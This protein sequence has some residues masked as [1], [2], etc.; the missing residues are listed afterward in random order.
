MLSGN[1]ALWLQFV[2]DGTIGGTLTSVP[3]LGTLLDQSQ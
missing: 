1:R 2:V 3:S